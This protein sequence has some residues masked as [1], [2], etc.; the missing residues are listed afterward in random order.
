VANGDLFPQLTGSVTP[1]TL[2]A[3]IDG[4]TSPSD[5]WRL[6]NSVARPEEPY[7]IFELT[8]SIT[9]SGGNGS[10]VFLNDNLPVS[11]V[12]SPAGNIF[13]AKE[14]NIAGGLLQ[15]G[16]AAGNQIEIDGKI[17]RFEIAPAPSDTSSIFYIENSG[18][19]SHIWEALQAKIIA[20]TSIQSIRI[21][22]NI[23]GGSLN[24][25]N[26]GSAYFHMTSSL[27]GTAGNIGAISVANGT[28]PASF[29]NIPNQSLEVTGGFDLG[30]Q[31]GMHDRHMLQF[32]DSP[33]N[34]IL[35][36]AAPGGTLFVAPDTMYVEIAT[37]SSSDIWSAVEKTLEHR[38]NHLVSF[39]PISAGRAQFAVEAPYSSMG[40][41]TSDVMSTNV[42]HSPSFTNIAG[43]TGGVAP[44]NSLDNV[45]RIPNSYGGFINGI[46]L[47]AT[48]SR[49]IIQNRFSSP[50]G[51]EVNTRG[52]LDIA[53]GEYSVHNNLNY[54]NLTV[55]G[56]G[57]GEVGTMRSD[58]LINRRDGLRT[59]RKRH[60]GKFGVESQYGQIS[61]DHYNIEAAFHKQHRNTF[62]TPRITGDGN[63][64]KAVLQQSTS[65]SEVYTFNESVGGYTTA[66]SSFSFWLNMQNLPS[67]G[68][69]HY[70]LQAKDS[71]GDDAFEIYIEGVPTPTLSFKFYFS[72]GS[73]KRFDKQFT[74]TNEWVFVTF[75]WDSLYNTSIGGTFYY[76]GIPQVFGGGG[77]SCITPGGCPD[78]VDWLIPK[79]LYFFDKFVNN[80]DFELQGSVADFAIWDH[81]LTDT[82]VLD[83]YELQGLATAHDKNYTLIDFWRFGLEPTL[84]PI[85]VGQPI[86]SETVIRSD[87]GANA[88]TVGNV[89]V[90]FRIS[91]GP[92]RV[93]AIVDSP[94]RNNLNFNSLLPASDFQ[95]SWVIN[96]I[97]GS[98]WLQQQR[99]RG[100]APKDGE[101]TTIGNGS[102]Y[103]RESAINFPSAS[104]LHG[105]KG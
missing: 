4:G 73:S 36:G 67:S 57:S 70:I 61:A 69:R 12:A 94:V 21:E 48:S 83:L 74:S 24:L 42:V 103:G 51:P 33:T 87:I 84:E 52:Y 23:S 16:A 85:G 1:L 89:G 49:H 40:G 44:T 35:T 41:N 55:R 22:P 63:F 100:Y 19:S 82:E 53:H 62:M 45:T 46:P 25:L 8:A 14:T 75:A 26:T 18:S 13:T 6:V 5:H 80:G 99:V 58:T 34:L 43:I 7:A 31:Y 60:S 93:K 2:T 3:S 30:H 65:T 29:S 72:G 105:V 54:R 104:T 59:L 66:P 96:A 71:V 10:I 101:I 92:Y 102:P 38:K 68:Q 91:E 81:R 97:S 28:S 56:S 64:R 50:G 77:S 76:N 78:P 37:G 88:L 95:Y 47:V 32:Q 9:G 27:N 79:K 11:S 17:F 39:S 20:Q 15:A 86:S 98:N 90:T